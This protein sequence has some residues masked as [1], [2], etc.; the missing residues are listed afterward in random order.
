MMTMRDRRNPERWLGLA[1]ATAVAAACSVDPLMPGSTGGTSGGAAGQGGSA[2]GDGGGGG[3]TGVGGTTGTGGTTGDGACANLPIPAIACA[4]GRTVPICT[5]DA[6][7][8]GFWMITCPDD[9]TGA[10]GA[11]G[12]VGGRAGAGGAGRAGAGGANGGASGGAPCTSSNACAAGEVC[13]TE[14]GDCRTPPGC[15]VNIACPGVCY[16][17]CR[18]ADSS[19]VC[20][21]ARC[22]AGT[23]CCNASCGICTAPGAGCTKQLCVPPAGG[24]ACTTDADCRVE[25]DYCTGCDCRPLASAQTV[26]PCAGP[27]V[28]CFADPCMGKSARCVS[29]LCAVAP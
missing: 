17:T 24:G 28:R 3:T 29:G 15:G 1:L 18:P 14:D 10:G 22:A 13:T 26:P 2:S 7:G 21:A 9:P 5:I 20:G 6:S 4:V 16:G 11:G 19:A 27:G 25:A 12:G 23:V 8:R